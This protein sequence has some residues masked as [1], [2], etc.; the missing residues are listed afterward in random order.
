MATAAVLILVVIL[1]LGFAGTYLL[2]RRF[3]RL[4]R[5]KRKIDRKINKIE[6]E[7]ADLPDDLEED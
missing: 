4:R 2:L 5:E 3:R 7:I 6:E 1:A